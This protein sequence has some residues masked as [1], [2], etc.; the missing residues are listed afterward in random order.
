LIA[1][2]NK[3]FVPLTDVKWESGQYG[4]KYLDRESESKLYNSVQD[5]RRK[6]W[7]FWIKVILALAALASTITSLV[8]ALKK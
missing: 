3:L 2:A 7:D 1:R 4:I 6:T 8:L 5:A